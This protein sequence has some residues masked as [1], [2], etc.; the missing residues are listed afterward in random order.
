M[1]RSTHRDNRQ[2]RLR[3]EDIEAIA[4][5][6]AELLGAAELSHGPLVDA[7]ELARLLGIERSWVYT[8]AIELGAVKLGG[9]SRPRLRFDPRLALERIRRGAVQDESGRRPPRRRRR[10]PGATPPQRSRLLPIKG[11]GAS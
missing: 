9:G 8:H 11:G 1:S 3:P 10:G 5:R 4:R 7:A 2:L 6:V